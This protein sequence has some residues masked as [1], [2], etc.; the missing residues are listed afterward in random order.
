MLI[1]KKPYCIIDIETTGLDQANDKI[2]EVYVKKVFPDGESEDLYSLINPEKPSSKDAFKVHNIDD[3][4]VADRDVFAK[5]AK[6]LFEFIDGIDLIGYNTS[7]IIKFLLTE[8]K[9][10]GITY[11]YKKAKVIDV[12]KM[13]FKNYN[14]NS[15]AFAHKFLTGDEMT[16]N[17]RAIA[18]VDAVEKVLASQRVLYE[19]FTFEAISDIVNGDNVDL[20]GNIIKKDG[21]YILNYGSEKKFRGKAVIEMFKKDMD[22]YRWIDNQSNMP[23]DSKLVLK[24]LYNHYK[25][26]TQK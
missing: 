5:I 23:L 21:T 13:W 19:D 18:D 20:S 16:N 17:H 14:P 7:F 25:K 3:G 24:L 12:Q 15:L 26:K 9:N 2:I 6:T 10:A 11:N 1:T 4:M 22:Y 8:F